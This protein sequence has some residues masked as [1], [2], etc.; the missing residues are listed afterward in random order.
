MFERTCALSQE[1]SLQELW[2]QARYNQ[3]YFQFLRGRY[4]ESLK[5]FGQLRA[6]FKESGSLRHYA[7]CD[8]DEAEIY[9]QLNI[10][11]DASTLAQNASRQFKELGMHY[12]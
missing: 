10:S 1:C 11:H 9:L 4:S 2:A 12:E 3:A 8:L 6:Y 7:L 5:S